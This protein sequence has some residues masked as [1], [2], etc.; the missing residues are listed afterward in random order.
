ML[1]RLFALAACAAALPAVAADPPTSP[2]EKHLHS[3]K[4][5]DGETALLL[6]LDAT[7]ADDEARFGLGVIR[8]VRAVETLGRSLHEYG[9]VSE[10][11]TQSFLR[12]PVPKND[13]PSA[14]SYKALGRVLD[15]F[16][17]DLLRAEQTLAAIKDDKVKLKL[18]LADI[19]L[20]FTGTGGQRVKLLALLTKLNGGRFDFEKKNPNLRVHFDRGDVAWLRAY[21][22]LLA[23]MV[24]AYRAV[25]EE[26]GFEERVQD[27][28]P[29][30]EATGKK[31]DPDWASG[32]TVVDPP[33]LRRMRLH[34]VAVCELNR[35][36]WTHIRAE[37][38]DDY[39]W[40]PKP[41][42][43]DQLGLPI[44]DAQIDAWLGMMEQLEG[45]LKGERLLA[46]MWIQ[47][48]HPKHPAGQGLNVK[49]LLDDPPAD[50]LNV[51][52]LRADGVAAKHL[53][54]E[55]GKKEFDVNALVAVWQALDGP[56]G[57]A[58]AVRLN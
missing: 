4:L 53:E 16:A 9:A 56:F 17:A 24:E 40:L 43:T 44:T 26:A 35:E 18:R 31:A 49:K 57:W 10:N 13:K 8:F 47:F 19:S 54:A 50:L 46:G 2:A 5:A 22:H 1:R 21:C 29:K 14:I 45:L 36:S 3:G 20:D 32:L 41:K 39:E 55:K 51:E 34:L 37:T 52:R 7:P 25:D 15:A 30:V 58:Y 23:A 6:A 27:V 38:D 48:V 33:R 12:L 28:F 11:A 42:Q